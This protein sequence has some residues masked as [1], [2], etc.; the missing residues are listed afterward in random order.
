MFLLMIRPQLAGKIGCGPTRQ[1]AS[2]RWMTSAVDVR[3]PPQ[4][5]IERF[6]G[7]G[8]F[9]KLAFSKE[10]RAESK[11]FSVIE[12]KTPRHFAKHTRIIFQVVP[13]PLGP[14]PVSHAPTTVAQHCLAPPTPTLLLALA[15][16]RPHR[17]P[18]R[19]A[20]PAPAEKSAPLLALLPHRPPR[21]PPDRTPAPI[22]LAS[23]IGAWL[24][25]STS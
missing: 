18:H 16:A 1:I 21:R 23:P 22:R 20:R 7:H 11:G 10:Q 24:L 17:C 6:V 9:Q 8:I 15:H 19:V 5:Q 14:V 4:P 2:G 12:T 25:M 3:S 13:S